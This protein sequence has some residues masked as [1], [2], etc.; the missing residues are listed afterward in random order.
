MFLL[1]DC[2]SMSL[3]FSKWISKYD[4]V[5][6]DE[7]IEYRDSSGNLKEEKDPKLGS[8]S[9]VFQQRGYL[10]REELRQIGRW[11]AGG[12]IDHHL[13]KNNQ[14]FHMRSSKR[15]FLLPLTGPLGKGITKNGW[16][17]SL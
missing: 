6:P 4:A 14:R 15:S 2:Q 9:Q 12:R 13:K 5:A 8:I 3:D 10:L 7:K 11:K 17:T 1:F 16:R